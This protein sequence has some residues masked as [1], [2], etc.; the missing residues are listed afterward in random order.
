MKHAWRMSGMVVASVTLLAGCVQ[1]NADK[2]AGPD[3]PGGVPTVLGTSG[4]GLLTATIPP[5]VPSRVSF[6]CWSHGLSEATRRNV[7]Q[8]LSFREAVA[9]MYACIAQRMPPEWPGHVA[10]ADDVRDLLSTIQ[11]KDPG[12]S[13]AP[14][15]GKY[16]S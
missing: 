16:Q 9:T 5:N 3:W 6:Q 8:D 7:G 4:N 1:P 13:I 14:W 2:A 11:P 10:A 15:T 12:F